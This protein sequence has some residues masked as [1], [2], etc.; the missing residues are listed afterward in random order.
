MKD[1]NEDEWVRK[2]RNG[3]VYDRK[4]ICGPLPPMEEYILECFTEKYVFKD[5]L[6]FK[7][8]ERE[9]L[10]TLS[11]EQKEGY[12]K[13][14]DMLESYRREREKKLVEFTR[15]WGRIVFD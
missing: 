10:N 2:E 3:R 1:F 9:F 5:A 12:Q 8:I 11:P 15:G 4:S 14:M 7:Q 13:I 6:K